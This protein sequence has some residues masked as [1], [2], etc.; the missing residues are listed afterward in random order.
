MFYRC[1]ESPYQIG[2][3]PAFPDG[4][5]AM[6]LMVQIVPYQTCF[7]PEKF[8][9]S[10]VKIDEFLMIVHKVIVNTCPTY[11]TNTCFASLVKKVV[12]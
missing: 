2:V 3:W 8:F 11:S 9:L 5:K 4:T 7:D 6:A 10:K 12:T 1:D